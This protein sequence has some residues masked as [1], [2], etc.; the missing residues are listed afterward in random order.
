[1]DER[2]AAAYEYDLPSALIAQEPAPQRDRARL[3]VVGR[4]GTIEDHVFADLPGV[5]RRGDLLVLN[6]TRVLPHRLRARRTSG[7][8]AEVLLLHPAAGLAYDEGARSWIALVRPSKRLHD[9]ERLDLCAH[10]GEPVATLEMVTDFGQG[11]REVRIDSALPLRELLARCGRLALPPYIHNESPQ[12]QERYQTVFARIPASVAAPTAALH[13]TQTLLQSLT[14]QGI[15]IAKLALDIG[16]GTFVPMHAER[17]DDHAMHAE[18]YTLP[19]QTVEAIEA[20]RRDKRRVVAVGTTVVRALEGNAAANGRLRAG[21]FETSLFITPGFAFSVVDALVTNFHLP[22]STLLVLVSA[23][24]GR[25][26]IL[27]A[28]REAVARG[29]RF[30]SFGDAMLLQRTV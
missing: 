10:G 21:E 6:E 11:R 7:G 2:S 4:D 19:V 30:Y 13:F 23:F 14:E 26:Q 28:Y 22:R 17:I 8:S 3:A 24:A 29:Y 5:L 15:G 20:A 18:R 27:A 12:A 1:M 16:A 9:G 25:E